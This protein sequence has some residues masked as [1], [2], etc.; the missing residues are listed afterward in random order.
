MQPRYGLHLGQLELGV[1]E[2]GDAAAELLALLDVSDGLLQSALSDAQS[3]GSDTDTAA[4]QSSHSQLEALAAHAQH[5]IL[6]DTA[7]LEDQL[8]GGRTTDAHLILSLADGEARIGALNDEGRAQ[9]GGA[10]LLI[11]NAVGDSDDDK[12]ISETGVG[13]EDL[14]AIQNPAVILFLGNGLLTLC[15]GTSAR[16][17]QAESAQP[18]AAAELAGTL[19][20]ARGCRSH[21]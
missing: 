14:G 4:V 16:L 11:Q 12:D 19:P 9:L 15:I 13:D 8:T 10:A 20:S 6:R 17:G 5:T 3:L 1:L 2:S 21:K 7:I 18:L